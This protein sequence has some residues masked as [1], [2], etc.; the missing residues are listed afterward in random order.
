LN[1]LPIVLWHSQQHDHI[2]VNLH[3]LQSA[4]FLP[5]QTQEHHSSAKHK[6]PMPPTS[7]A[8]T[9]ASIFPPSPSSG[10]PQRTAGTRPKNGLRTPWSTL[11]L[12]PGHP[13]MPSAVKPFSPSPPRRVLALD[14]C[15]RPVQKTNCAPDLGSMEFPPPPA[16]LFP[17]VVAKF[18]PLMTTVYTFYQDFSLSLVKNSD[19]R[20]GGAC[21]CIILSAGSDS[22]PLT[23]RESGC[24]S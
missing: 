2:L 19:T 16:V 11:P 10:P 23:G 24:N 17:A 18:H 22:P 13:N 20:D 8:P 1:S 12:P 9:V 6:S 21:P 15:Q 7:T 3:D 4:A 5:L 14:L